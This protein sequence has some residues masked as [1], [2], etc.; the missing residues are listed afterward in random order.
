MRRISIDYGTLWV[1]QCCTL[2]H[3]N[4]EC[5]AD[6]E[7]GG[8]G[9]APWSAIDFTRFRVWMGLDPE[10]HGCERNL[11]HGHEGS[12]YGCDCDRI[13]FSRSWCDGCGSTLAGERHAFWLTRER[14]S[15]VRPLLP[16]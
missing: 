6:N 14:Q 16:A 13:T 1:C 12:D 15:F 2:Q 7:H 9:I 11:E 5:C 8:D 4:G 10:D 3:A